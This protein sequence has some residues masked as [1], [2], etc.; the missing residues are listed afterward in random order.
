MMEDWIEEDENGDMWECGW[1]LGRFSRRLV[2]SNGYM[3]EVENYR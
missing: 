2:G 3:N 1:E